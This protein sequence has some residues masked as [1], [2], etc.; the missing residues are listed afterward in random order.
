MNKCT[1]V[2]VHVH[3][4]QARNFLGSPSGFPSGY[5]SLAHWPKPSGI[6]CSCIKTFA[7]CRVHTHTRTH[8]HT[9]TDVLAQEHDLCTISKSTKGKGGTRNLCIGSCSFRWSV[10]ED[11]YRRE[12]QRIK[13]GHCSRVPKLKESYICRDSW[14][15]LNV[16]PSKIL[17]VS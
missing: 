9:H 6:N 15:R 2:S 13:S 16:Q 8:T 10:I 3:T 4:C 11:M 14:T 7:S 17:Q 5:C 12:L 1:Y